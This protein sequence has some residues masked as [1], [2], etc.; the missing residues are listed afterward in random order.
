MTELACRGWA[1]LA[2][3]FLLVAG[4]GAPAWAQAPK[5]AGLPAVLRWGGD[6]SGGEPYIVTHRDTEPDG[7]EG[8][9]AQY[10]AKKLGV[11]SQFVNGEWDKLPD[12]LRAERI[13]MVLNGY[14]WSPQREKA[15]LSTIPYYS[16]RLRLVVEKGSR[17]RGWDDLEPG[18]SVG[19]LKDSAA[20]RYLREHY[21]GLD[22]LPLGEEGSTGVMSMV[23]SRLQAT[24]QDDVVFSWYLGRQKRFPRL[25]VVGDPVA[26][27]EHSYFVIFVR[28]DDTALRDALDDALRQGLKDGTLRRIYIKYGLWPDEEGDLLR[29]GQDWP[30]RAKVRPEATASTGLSWEHFL[31][32]LGHG[33]AITILLTL[34]SMPL[35]MLIG[36]TVALGRLYGP[37]WLAAALTFYVEVIRGTPV[38]FQLMVLF[39]GLP[40][41]AG[42]TLPAFWA[43]VLGLAINYGAY[44]AENYRA[45]LLAIPR[46]QMEA[47]LALGMSKATALRRVIVP[48]A[49]R[50]VVPPVTN[51]F[52]SLFKD[53]SICSAIAVTELMA[54]YR[55]LTVNFPEWAVYTLVLAGSLY[56]LMSYPLSVLTRRVE[57]RQAKGRVEG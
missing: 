23:G 39:F 5:Q 41:I 48:Q 21:R 14:E 25:Q 38:L 26:P 57:Q 13:D 55:T 24:V 51:D 53:T 1:A 28:R 34:L 4:L 46:G 56:L 7:F 9:L 2:G 6:A 11:R 43:G 30:P 18:T 32:D 8:E 12:F 31:G 17:I 45:G 36:L 35:A 49:V 19:V 33:A 52:I 15:M 40:Q 44:E 27:S 50:L 3:A 37:G 20:E 47:A 10:L 54:R 22:L 16:F 29:A 42:I